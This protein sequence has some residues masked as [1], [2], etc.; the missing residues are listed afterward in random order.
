[1]SATG[2]AADGLGESRPGQRER[3][4]KA[5]ADRRLGITSGAAARQSGKPGNQNGLTITSTTISASRIAG[6]SPNSFSCFSLNGRAP[7]I[8]FFAWT[9]MYM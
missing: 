7:P 8:I 1:M 3:F 6:T 2:E 5:S 9:T 4:A